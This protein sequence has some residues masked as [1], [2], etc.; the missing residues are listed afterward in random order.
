[1]GGRRGRGGHPPDR[2]ARPQT[3]RDRRADLPRAAGQHRP[4]I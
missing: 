2:G 1:M 4:A 3:R